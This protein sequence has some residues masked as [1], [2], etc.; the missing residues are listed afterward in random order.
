MSAIVISPSPEQWS[1]IEPFLQR[2]GEGAVVVAPHAQAQAAEEGITVPAY[3][4]RYDYGGDPDVWLDVVHDREHHAW[5]HITE[6]FHQ[7]TRNEFLAQA[8]SEALTHQGL[9][10]GA[11]AVR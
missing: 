5:D 2:L 3:L 1:V 6:T 10:W 7:P 8:L 9:T 11:E 4:E